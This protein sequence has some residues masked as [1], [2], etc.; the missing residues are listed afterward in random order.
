M[1]GLHPAC[2]LGYDSE[3]IVGSRTGHSTRPNKSTGSDRSK[4]AVSQTEDSAAAD[5]SGLTVQPAQRTFIR[6]H[7]QATRP[8]PDSSPGCAP[9]PA[10]EIKRLPLNVVGDTYRT[11][12]SPIYIRTGDLEWMPADNVSSDIL[13]S[14]VAGSVAMYGAGFLKH[15]DYLRETGLLSGE[16]QISAE[17]FDSINQA[18]LLS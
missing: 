15:D 2:P 13:Y 1:R 18:G 5:E 6:H 14:Y 16:A 11:F 7:R 9:H 3:L 17:I 10:V 12:T 8:A 4:Y